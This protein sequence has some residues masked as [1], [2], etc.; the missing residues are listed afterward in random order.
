MREVMEVPAPE[1]SAEVCGNSWRVLGA[2]VQGTGHVKTGQPC[3]DSFAWERLEGGALLIAVADG[4][5]SAAL[6]EIGATVAA[7][8]AVAALREYAE[9]RRIEGSG[10]ANPDGACW[11]GNEEGWR[12]LFLTAFRSALEAVEMEAWARQISMRELASTLILAVATP[13]QVACA[14]VGDG[15]AVAMDREGRLLALSAPQNGESMDQTT[16]LVSPDAMEKV[17][18]SVWRGEAAHLALF[19]DGLQMLA[20]KMPAGTP[21]E[22]FFAPLFRFAASAEEDAAAVGELETFLRSPRVTERTDDD[23]TLVIATREG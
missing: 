20:L 1:G 2:S 23:L 9:V 4:A 10:E 22:P 13:D 18:T 8:T 19:S 12:D 17:Q 5:G 21:H 14:Q 6:G 11:P 16:F 3:Q 7:Q 15:A